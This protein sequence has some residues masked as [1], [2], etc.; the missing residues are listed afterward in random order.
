MGPAA[1]LPFQRRVL[2]ELLDEDALCIVARG[3]GVGRILAELAR[4]CA[5]PRALVFLVNASEQ[6]EAD[7]QQ[8]LM[9]MRSG[10]QADEAARL[11]VVKNETNAA[12]RGQVYRR[13]GL[14]SVTSRILIVDL[15]NGVVPAELVTGVVVH[16]ASRVTAESIEAFVLRVVRQ[17]NP[18]A[19][20]KAL[21]DAPE[22][23]TAG[24]APLEKTLKVL[25]LRHVH[26]WPRFHVDV[27]Q[28]LSLEAAPVVELRVPQTRSMVELQQAVLD[29]LS[30]TIGELCSATRLLDPESINVESSLFRHF[31]AMVKRQLSPHWHR[32]SARVRGMAG[33]LALLR[34]VAELITAYDPVSLLE[35]LDALLLSS[36]PTAGAAPGPAAS[37]M[38]SDAAN[39][40]YAVARTRTFRKVAR[41]QLPPQTQT[42]LRALG[43]PDAI[44]PVLEVPPKLALLAQI[45]DEIGVANSTAAR[46]G[47]AAGPV[48]VMAESGRECRM[49]RAFLASLHSH[50]EFDVPQGGGGGAGSRTERHPRVM[51]DMLRSFFRWKAQAT[52]IRAGG[53]ASAG[54]PASDAG[55]QRGRPPP[56][57]RRRVRGASAAGARLPRAPAEALEQETSD[58]AA[59][60]AA[61]EPAAPEGG[62]G[63][64][65]DDDEWAAALGAFDESFGLLPGSET[66]LVHAYASRKDVLRA[67]QPTHVV[68][69]DPSPAFIREVEV[70]QARGGPLAQVYFLV[71]DN[72]LEEQRYL[73]AIRR[74]RESFERLIREKATLVIP[75]GDA[76]AGVAAAASPANALMHTI[77]ARSQRSARAV[78]GV[79]DAQPPQPPRIVVDVREFRAPLPSLLHMAGFEVVPRT[80]DVGDYVLHDNLV[81]E[82]KSLPDL[83]GSLRSGR[84][85]NQADAMTRHYG[86]A[87]L[88]IEF[89][90]NTSFSLQALGGITADIAVGSI[91]SQLTMLV[92]AF[93]RLRIIW[94][95]SPYE[96]VH[97]F[98]ELKRGACEP[99]IDKAVAVGQDDAAVEREAVYSQAPIA[100]L[101]ALPGVTR[102]NYQLLARAFRSIRDLA[103]A[104]EA[105]I[106]EA[107]GAD[108]AQKLH[109]FLHAEAK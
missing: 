85:F 25:G 34:R 55:A 89:E 83:V 93:P 105:D 87:A 73:S 33:D 95:A 15:L 11:R 54:P 107:V 67:L 108:A 49:I 77:A 10:E 69:Y 59:E 14:I 41:E 3:L 40:L 22:A 47:A 5:T 81:V 30:A 8:Q 106:A 68:L 99:S 12:A 74:E 24:F 2:D 96:T 62:S 46:S 36:R 90:V 58:M 35:Y 64:L 98:A 76:G 29:C 57:K 75:V 43:L 72:S 79:D 63:Y 38:A 71:Y 48:L 7:L 101:Q 53:G 92:L 31:D 84:L 1:L 44:V 103:A 18:G 39:I 66:V 42:Q 17:Q 97:I 37:W 19:F 60:L 23:F 20:V 65:D 94:S 51:V 80:I 32:L 50:V 91:T 86:H 78:P 45:L 61:D 82:R 104:S 102:K 28:D 6:D 4:A 100:L 88:L 21:S 52:G 16:N 9:Q 70:Y 109:G 13:G 26:L 56:T 27:Q